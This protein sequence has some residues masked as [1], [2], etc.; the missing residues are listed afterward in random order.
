MGDVI[1]FKKAPL[2][3]KPIAPVVNCI[4]SEDHLAH[5]AQSEATV[6]SSSICEHLNETTSTQFAGSDPN[7]VV[8]HVPVDIADVI[9]NDALSLNT[10]A[11]ASVEEMDPLFAGKMFEAMVFEALVILGL[12]WIVFLLITIWCI[13]LRATVSTLEPSCVDEE[14]DEESKPCTQRHFEI[15]ESRFRDGSYSYQ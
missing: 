15:S 4:P 3:K 11:T 7:P 2:K 1:F 10:K 12:F 8:E 5:S 14:L 6:V 9:Q 13:C